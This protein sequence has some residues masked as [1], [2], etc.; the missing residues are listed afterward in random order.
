MREGELFLRP[1]HPDIHQPALLLEASGLIKGPNVREGSLLD[2]NH[3]YL[4]KLEPLGGVEG[5][6]R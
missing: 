2:A 4:I 3:E 5:H 1:G 6:Q